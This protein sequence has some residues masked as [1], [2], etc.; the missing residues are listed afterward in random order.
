MNSPDPPRPARAAPASTP[1][2]PGAA[3]GR[4]AAATE[5]IP[6]LPTESATA[7]RSGTATSAGRKEAPGPKAKAAPGPKAKETA[8][9]EAGASTSPKGRKTNAS[10]AHGSTSSTA[11]ES[12]GS[13]GTEPS[14]SGAP[15]ALKEPAAESPAGRSGNEDKSGT[16]AR[17]GTGTR[18][19]AT[20]PAQGR[21][22]LSP[23]SLFSPRAASPR[24]TDTAL[25]QGEEA[26]GT[27]VAAAAV[28]E[29]RVPDPGHDS[30]VLAH[31]D[32]GTD[33]GRIAG[34]AAEGAASRRGP[35]ALLRGSH[36]TVL[37]VAA[38]TGVVL[39]AGVLVGLRGSAGGHQDTAAPESAATLL[40]PASDGSKG[41]VPGALPLPS[42]HHS[43]AAATGGHPGKGASDH[44]KHAGSGT[45]KDGDT[46]SGTSPGHSS[47]G[48]S[49]SSH[50]GGTT[51]DGTSSSSS[52]HAPAAQDTEAPAFA[53]H[54]T[55]PA[56]SGG[57]NTSSGVMVFSHA[58]HRCITV[59]GGQGRDGS[60][61]EIRDC[62]G[63]AAQKWTFAS[64]GTVR[65]FGLCMDAAG[66]SS[67]N[68]T[69]VQLANCN[70]G[71]AQQFRLNTSHDLT[72]VMQNKCVDVKDEQTA[73]GTRLQL[74]T[75]AGTDNQKWSKE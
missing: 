69:V 59:S 4:S 60:P 50:G 43:A 13:E 3:L 17:A 56:S 48:S 10:K 73:N 44:G 35:R 57:S 62:T 42:G 14:S 9:S 21:S 55:A 45:A 24:S 8:A 34:D 68:G 16:P 58:S 2:T 53:P 63:S 47:S 36:R 15:S 29:E 12:T 18:D 39:V 31:S 1:V 46:G 41:N 33:E 5:R 65:A 67:A 25:A 72:N 54:T 66:G 71:P 74:W 75:C 49:T 61:L 64:D 37:T 70:G 52:G 28:G 19:T 32:A 6:P 11:E 30:D 22:G 27:P 20:Q 38:V 7:S 26:S 51:G 23:L 40:D